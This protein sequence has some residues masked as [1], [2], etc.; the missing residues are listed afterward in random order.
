MGRSCWKLE[1]FSLCKGL[2]FVK[3]TVVKCTDQFREQNIYKLKL[4]I[5]SIMD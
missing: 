5:N 1:I 4:R 3:A 2:H